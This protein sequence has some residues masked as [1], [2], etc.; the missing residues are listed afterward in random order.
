MHATQR[1]ETWHERH[2]ILKLDA[3]HDRLAC[4]LH[5]QASALLLQ[6]HSRSGES[7]KPDMLLEILAPAFGGPLTIGC[8]MGSRCLCPPDYGDSPS[9]TSAVQS[10]YVPSVRRHAARKLSPC[11]TER[12]HRSQ[13]W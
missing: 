6:A 9:L 11:R 1:V 2:A 13:I 7:T 3:L 5:F 12:P 8:V 4:A 10:L